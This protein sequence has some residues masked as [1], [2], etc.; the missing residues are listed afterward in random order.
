MCVLVSL[1]TQ[2]ACTVSYRQSYFELLQLSLLLLLTVAETTRTTNRRTIERIGVWFNLATPLSQP[3]SSECHK[4]LRS[5]ID[6][7]CDLS[8][9]FSSFSLVL[10]SAALVL[11]LLFRLLFIFRLRLLT[12]SCCSV[13]GCDCN[14][15]RGRSFAFL[16]DSTRCVSSGK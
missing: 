4:C 5:P 3:T 2:D 7:W 14:G 1:R 8:T 12:V 13:D 16:C 6:R 10:Y 15:G 11:A 9:R